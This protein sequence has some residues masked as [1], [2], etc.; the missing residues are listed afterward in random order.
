[1]KQKKYRYAWMSFSQYEQP[2]IE[3][4]VNE[5]AAKGYEIS[6][7]ARFYLRFKYSGDIVKPYNVQ[8]Y[9][10][11]FL[12]HWYWEYSHETLPQ[13]KEYGSRC[14]Y[15][16][17]VV[18][19]LTCLMALSV[20]SLFRFNI[21]L[22]YSDAMLLGQLLLPIFCLSFLM[23][24]LGRLWES[25]RAGKSGLHTYRFARFRA[26]SLGLN[27]IVRYLLLFGLLLPTILK[28]LRM[29]VV[30]VILLVSIY[31]VA[32]YYLPHRHRLRLVLLSAV[33]AL[34]GCLTMTK[35]NEYRPYQK[36][37]IDYSQFHVMRLEDFIDEQD[38]DQQLN[39]A[40]Q[41][42]RYTSM[43]LF[44][45]LYY[46]RTETMH[47]IDAQAPFYKTE[48]TFSYCRNEAVA[49]YLF[50]E[51]APDDLSKVVMLDHE[52]WQTDEIILL[53]SNHIMLRK[54]VVVMEFSG[55]F[56]LTN[57]PAADMLYQLI[58]E[59]LTETLTD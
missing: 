37:E 57:E 13:R 55:T 4:Y 21:L 33:L 30:F 40:R 52:I 43:S 59:T 56:D 29:P 38:F 42:H 22:L 11:H 7:I 58:Q 50:W 5:Q 27:M 2:V 54:G 28:E 44:V 17:F 45:P 34:I 10:R 14:F 15:H 6:K 35:I 1:M 25:W 32:Y 41:V 8:G 19:F 36:D 26:F 51:K 49:R 48:S 12:G 20:F 3:A 47:P 18:L 24:Y 46:K 23:D 16:L 31:E 9:R 39:Y 53:E